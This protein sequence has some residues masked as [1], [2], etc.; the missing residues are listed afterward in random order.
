MPFRPVQAPG[1]TSLM[2]ALGKGEL[3]EAILAHDRHN[4]MRGDFWSRDLEFIRRKPRRR[5]FIHHH[6]CIC[7][8][9]VGGGWDEYGHGIEGHGHQDNRGPGNHGNRGFV[10]HG[11]HPVIY[12]PAYFMQHISAAY[13]GQRVLHQIAQDQGNQIYGEERERR[14]EDRKLRDRIRRLERE[15]RR[16]SRHRSYSRHRHR[17][18]SPSS[19]RSR[20]R[21]GYSSDSDSSD[22][23]RRR[24]HYHRGGRHGGNNGN[25]FNGGRQGTMH[26]CGGFAAGGMV[27][28]QVYNGGW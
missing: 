3:N 14:R 16:R 22:D 10:D 9:C 6:G 21:D 13:D 17:W 1:A 25:C 19:S 15:Q 23:G 27:P 2:R 11:N 24:P 7:R 28:G 5:N 26:N 18:R 4:R 8:Q 20:S 12:D